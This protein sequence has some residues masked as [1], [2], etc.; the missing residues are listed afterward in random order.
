MQK[1]DH[2]YSELKKFLSFYAARY[3]NVSGLP[4]EKQPMSNLETLER[5][6]GKSAWRGLRQ[7]IN[8]CVEM[9]FHLDPK[10]VRKLDAELRDLGIVTVS[11]LRRRYSKKYAAI[12]KRGRIKDDTEYYLIRNV[13]GDVTKKTT[14]ESEVLERLIIEY[15][16]A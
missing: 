9:S 13:A 14:E 16:G 4:P 10:D 2:E 8:D 5:K 3:L 6:G 12:M 1:A 15:E 11:E 7:A